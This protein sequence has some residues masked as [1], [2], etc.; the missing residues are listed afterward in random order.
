MAASATPAVSAKPSGFGKRVRLLM[1]ACVLLALALTHPT[2]AA[3]AATLLPGFALSRVASGMAD[4][5]AMA[6]APDGRIFVSEQGGRLR[7][8]KNGSLLATPFVTV[9]VDSTVERGL[10]GVTFDPDFASNQWVYIYY[11]ATSP[12]T[13]NRIT[14]WTANGDV[15]VPG[16]EV[17]IFALDPLGAAGNHNGG[18][19]HFGSDGKLYAA[20]GDNTR[21]NEAQ[22]L[23]SQL[24]KILRINKDGSI[25]ADNPFYGSTTGKNRAIWAYGF[26]NPFTIAFQPGTGRLFAND[27]GYQTAEEVNDVIRGGNYGWPATEGYTTNP[28]YRS[29]I[30]A[31]GHG[32]GGAETGCAVTGGVFYNPAVQQFP[33]EY[34]GDYFFADYCSGW[35]RRIDTATNTV[36]PFA[37]VYYLPID[38]RLAPDGSL[39]Y[40]A[41]QTNSVERIR[42]TGSQAPSIATHPQN[43]TVSVGQTA[44][45]SVTANGTAP[46]SYQWQ[47]NGADISGAISASYTT[48]ATTLSDNGAQF[49]VKVTNSVSNVTSNAA[50][51]TVTSNQPPSATISAPGASTTYAGGDTINYA[52]S[53]SDPEDGTLGAS[54]FTWWA[55]F[56]HDT[57]HHPFMPER[58][59]ATSGSFVIPRAGESSTNVWYR[60]YLRVRDSGGRTTTVYRD[61]Q[62]RVRSLTITTNPGGLQITLDGSPHTAPYTVS[63][64]E[65]VTRTIGV[66]SPQTQGGTSYA[67]A[68][69]S[70]GG[71]I[72]H[73]INTPAVNTTYTAT[74][75][76]GGGGGAGGSVY[77]DALA[78]GWVNWS[79]G[80]TVDFAATA[81]VYSGNR[82]IALTV[83]SA[84]GAL[85]LHSNTNVNTAGLTHLQF[86][87]RGSAAGQRFRVAL[88]DSSY[89]KLTSV[90]LEDHGGDPVAGSWKLYSIPLSALGATGK[91][92]SGIQI[93]DRNG[94][95]QPVLYIDAISF[96]PAAGT[97]AVSAPAGEDPAVALAARREE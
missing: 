12:N 66:A 1:S 20:V 60:L 81:P 15:A 7:V 58:S 57:H 3:E 83:T 32:T 19:I 68:S 88:V 17:L 6:V 71:A 5:T 69:W 76:A 86:A 95:P 29:P 70:D 73:D 52:G 22:S 59:G 34:V 48:P 78:S 79:W 93:Q 49:R 56:H 53:A 55:D 23:N 26:R 11:T 39:L 75:Q 10:L 4:P 42:F 28:A 37:T 9:T 16:S 21:P 94:A 13:H 91:Q 62:P 67:F 33:S 25:P 54:A 35:I 77:A 43:Q 63:S 90:A 97:A 27:V 24:G 38:L 80:S 61:I 14:R 50:T 51:L 92:I 18:A 2:P 89:Q 64:V 87:A 65:G 72:S 46:L 30:Y 84:W 45:F 74:F 96:G 85:N 31:Y 44:T 8:I 82:A 47:R 41:R 40:L 36:H